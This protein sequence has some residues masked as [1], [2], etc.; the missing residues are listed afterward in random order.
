MS[1]TSAKPPSSPKGSSQLPRE[2]KI[3]AFKIKIF[4]RGLRTAFQT[5]KSFA[6]VGLLSL[7]VLTAAFIL[8]AWLDVLIILIVTGLL[9]TTELINTALEKL[10]DLVEPNFDG[11]IGQIKDIAAAATG[12]IFIV[13]LATLLIEVIRIWP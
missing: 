1:L 5:D 11:R 7:I 6:F 12:I 13:W 2:L 8:Q 10:C 4:F 9:V 3:L